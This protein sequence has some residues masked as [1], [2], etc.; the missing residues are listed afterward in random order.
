MCSPVEGHR[1]TETSHFFH[2][3]VGIKVSRAYLLTICVIIFQHTG[4][5]FIRYNAFYI[6]IYIGGSQRRPRK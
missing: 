6:Y 4:R 1:R 3:I 2:K 5:I